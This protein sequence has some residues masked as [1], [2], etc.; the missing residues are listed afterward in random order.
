MRAVCDDFVGVAGQN[1]EN[2][3]AFGGG[4]MGTA[5][6]N[7]DFSFARG[8]AA[9]QILENFRA[10]SFHQTRASSPSD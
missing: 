6:A 4:K 8:A 2:L 5:G 3:G 10:E 7:G 9:A 1:C